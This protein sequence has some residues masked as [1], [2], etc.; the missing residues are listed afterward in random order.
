MKIKKL[1][2][3]SSFI[4]GCC[5]LA[6]SATIPAKKE[7]VETPPPS[8]QSSNDIDRVIAVVNREVITERELKDR[9]GFYK[10]QLIEEKKPIPSD[11][12]LN[13]EI[14][15]KLVDDSILSQ[16]AT[17]NRE[18]VNDADLDSILSN[19]A[20]QKKMTLDQYKDLVQKN[21]VNWNKYREDIRR[22][23]LVARYRQKNLESK[24]KVSES[25][26][27]A[28]V[29]ARFGGQN[30][31]AQQARASQDLIDVAQILVPIPSGASAS[32]IAQ[33]KLKA[34]GIFDRAS[35][36]PEFLKFANQAVQED[37]TLK[38]Q[39]FG[40]RTLDRLPQIF[41]DAIGGVSSGSMAA[42]IIQSP[43]GFHILK[44]IER[45]SAS[46][47]SAGDVTRPD[48]VYVSQSDINELMITTKPGFGEEDVV[49]KLKG[50]REQIKAK[51]I[52]FEDAA[53]KYSEDPNAKKNNGHL[54]WISAG[55]AP[56]EFEYAITQLSPGE[57]SSPFKTEFGWHII[58]LLN[59]KQVEVSNAQQREYARATLRQEKILQANDEFI[60]ES[61]DNSTIEIR[62]PYKLPNN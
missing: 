49:R 4:F 9:V 24:I 30:T 46:G 44:V 11:E 58:Q 48:A 2:L 42:Q 3:L 15:Q 31:V 27:D 47:T 22:D 29:N 35:K 51:I 39:D 59:K 40:P 38:A 53:K 6:L 60:R 20:S 33:L 18:R 25:E 23:I 41:I 1:V 55:M 56:P 32:E 28:F 14:L 34:Q 57:I 10:K 7:T 8:V 43:A 17:M 54:G 5:H 62:P 50:I 37:K 26:I 52:S 21:G 13:Q 19:L 12:I 45:R 61:R 36:D 16:E